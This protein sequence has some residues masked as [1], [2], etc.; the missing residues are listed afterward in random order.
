MSMSETKYQP[1]I[2]NYVDIEA[3]IVDT[4]AP[5]RMP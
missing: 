1:S 5:G 3:N 4:E 2:I